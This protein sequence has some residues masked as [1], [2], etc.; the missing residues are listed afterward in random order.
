[1]GVVPWCTDCDRY[2][3][4]PSVNPDGTCPSCGRPVD[5]GGARPAANVA[6]G[7]QA[8]ASEDLPAVPWHFKLLCAAVVIYLGYRFAQM[9]E[10]LLHRL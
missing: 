6:A 10:W 5:A 4:Y 9:A 2:L 7:E 1:M 8:A 3:A